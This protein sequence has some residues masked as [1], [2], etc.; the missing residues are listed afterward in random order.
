MPDNSRV[1]LVPDSTSLQRYAHAAR[2]LASHENKVDHFEWLRVEEIEIATVVE[3]QTEKL[4]CSYRVGSL[5]M[6][7]LV[8]D[9]GDSQCFVQRVARGGYTVG[10]R[11]DP[12]HMTL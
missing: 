6:H 8:Y 11:V 4:I 2:V 10:P 5:S 9:L 1:V 12:A 3:Q 7:F